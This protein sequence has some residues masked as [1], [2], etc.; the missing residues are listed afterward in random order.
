[1]RRP[2]DSVVPELKHAAIIVMVALAAV[3]MAGCGALGQGQ[4]GGDDL[5]D[6]ALA[7]SKWI[8][9]NDM[10]AFTAGEVPESVSGDQDWEESPNSPKWGFLR[11]RS[12]HCWRQH[13]AAGGT[14]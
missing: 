9:V 11:E 10:A 12:I 8:V 1:M 6:M 7:D 14:R 2:L 5:L 3:V 13:P 4:S